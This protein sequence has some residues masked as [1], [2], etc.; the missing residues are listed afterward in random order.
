MNILRYELNNIEFFTIQTTGESGMSQSGLAR[1]CGV[2]QKAVDNLLERLGTSSCP[3]FLQSLQG[4]G[5]TLSTSYHEY[6]NVTILKDSV[7][8]LILEWYAFESQRPTEKARQA[9]RQF[10]AVG[11]RTWIQTLTG[12]QNFTTS[13]IPEK[14]SK[15]SVRTTYHPQTLEDGELS[16]LIKQINS[17]QHHL[18]IALKHRHAIHNIVEKPVA[19][20]LSLNRVVHTAVH[21]QAAKLNQALIALEAIREQALAL[22]LLTQKIPESEKITQSLNQLTNVIEQMRQENN[23]LKS[24]IRQQKALLQ[25]RRQISPKYQ[26]ATTELENLDQTLAP[27]IQEIT[28]I[29]MKSQKRQG[30]T[31]AISTCTRRAEIY[32][33]YEI[34]QSLEEIAQALNTPY[35]TVK[36][37]VKLTRKEMKYNT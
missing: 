28:A 2:T 30:G 34:G 32:A 27:R 6:H 18:K 10:A 15:Q 1:M 19:V 31:R 23:H 13:P 3:E 37:Y 11:I 25:S 21:E 4:K 8:A 35:Q 14:E 16:P 22:E 33:R 7:C 29:L 26:L 36:S 12:W 17:L 20:D 9:F 24:I 5:L